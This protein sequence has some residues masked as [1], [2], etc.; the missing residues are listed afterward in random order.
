[1]FSDVSQVIN[2]LRK[3]IREARLENNRINR[4]QL[5]FV[6]YSMV[7]AVLMLI[8]YSSARIIFAYLDPTLGQVSLGPD[9]VALCVPTAVIALHLMMDD[10][11]GKTI[12]KRLKRFAG[13]GVFLFIL[14]TAMMLAT[15]YMESADGVG[16]GG[17]EIAINGTVGNETIGS[18]GNHTSAVFAAFRGFLSGVTP[19][20][21][22]TGMAAILWVTVYTSHRLLTKIEERYK[23]FSGAARRYRALKRVFAEADDAG[24]VIIQLDSRL[25]RARSKLPGDPEYRFAQIA[26]AAFADALHRMAKGL[27]GL[28]KTNELFDPHWERSDRVPEHIA[29]TKDG[30]RVIASLRQATTPYAILAHLDGLPVKDEEED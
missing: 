12:E 20:V 21:F 15:V 25:N 19:I 3:V 14:G 30:Q 17:S 13:V 18:G 22:F 7:V 28:G 16:T 27:R 6:L 29:T 10:E 23:Y 4:A 8:D 11:G 26:S 24:R 5:E 2:L 1:M 9:I